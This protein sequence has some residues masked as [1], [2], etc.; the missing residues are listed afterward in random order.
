MV[1][2]TN[3]PILA[4]LGAPLCYA[5]FVPGFKQ[6]ILVLKIRLSPL[7]EKAVLIQKEVHD[8]YFKNTISFSEH[9]L[10]NF[11]AYV[12]EIQKQGG[13]PVFDKPK[14]KYCEHQ[15]YEIS[16]P[17]LFPLWAM[18][19]ANFVLSLFNFYFTKNTFRV[20][21]KWQQQ[22]VHLIETLKQHAP[23]GSNSLRFL[24]AAHELNIPWRHIALNTFQ[25]GFGKNARWMD[26]SILDRTPYLSANLAQNKHAISSL[27]LRHGFPVPLQYAATNKSDLI[28]YAKHI[29]Y[30]VVL[31]PIDGKGGA[32]VYTNIKDDAGL[33]SAFDKI[34]SHSSTVLVEKHIVG[35]DYRLVVLNGKMIWAIE[36]VPAHVIGNGIDTIKQLVTTHNEK[37]QSVY[38]LCHLNLN[39]NMFD[40]L[41]EKNLHIE[42]V[43]KADQRILLSRTSNI[44]DGGTPIGIFEKVHPSTIRLVEEAAKL[45]R[46]DLIGI[47]MI[48]QD[49]EQ[50]YAE[51]K[52]MLIE[53]NVQPQLGFIT[54]S[55][56]YKQILSTTIP[57]HGRIPITVI[58]GQHEA[59]PE[60]VT[61]LSHQLG[62]K[63]AVAHDNQIS[64]NGVPIRSTPDLFTTG[65][66]IL[67]MKE[68][69][70]MIYCIKDKADYALTGLPF[71]CF[72]QL[73]LLEQTQDAAYLTPACH[74]RVVSYDEASHAAECRVD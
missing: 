33:V 21:A 23:Q 38:P 62:K 32:H 55:H 9:I 48:S 70:A 3:Q 29:G 11:A 43:P 50:S 10:E 45:L 26:S 60:M 1:A 25:F 35:K 56:I 49:I 36:R 24:Q 59:L 16:L 5:G 7:S 44:S 28:R 31:K 68:V 42:H 19:V 13:M 2:L 40:F 58:L 6:P 27:L 46:L 37:H 53:I 18:E 54:T 67:A 74:G 61:T 39:Q 71:D 69:D 63:V 4:P 64:V 17:M 52:G 30:P 73:I 20:D 47:D 15:E 8:Y 34:K 12:S 65:Q 41:R 72:D 57:A 14:I 66:A 51:N 22:L